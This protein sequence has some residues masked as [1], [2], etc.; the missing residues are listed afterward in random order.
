MRSGRVRIV[1]SLVASVAVALVISITISYLISL[2]RL[3]Q[4]IDR[5]L[6]Q[7][8]TEVTAF[9]ETGIDPVTARP[10]TDVGVLLRAVHRIERGRPERDHDRVRQRTA[11]RP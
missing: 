2:E 5:D 9:A 1:G 4:R 7:E 8:V 6:T 10:F 3:D 11:V